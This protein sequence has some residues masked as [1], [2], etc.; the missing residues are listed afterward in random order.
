KWANLVKSLNPAAIETIEEEIKDGAEKETV[1]E[2]VVPDDFEEL[3]ESLKSEVERNQMLEEITVK[4]G[5]GFTF[6]SF[7]NNLC[8]DGNSYILRDEV[9]TV[10]DDFCSILGKYESEIGQIQV[11]G[12]T[13]EVTPGENNILNDRFLSSNRAASVL[14]YMQE[15]DIFAPEKLVSIGYGQYRPIADNTTPDGR[16]SNRRVELLITKKDA[17]V[18]SLEDYY[19]EVY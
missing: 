17:V 19:K 2:V 15:K 10:L 7:K 14:V 4:K 8:F 18:R 9:K 11:L 1:Q 6:I 5:T 13:A 16:A 3:Y 12:H